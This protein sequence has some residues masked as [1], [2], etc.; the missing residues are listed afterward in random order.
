M[1]ANLVWQRRILPNGLTVLYYPRLST[2]TA[3]LSVTVNYGSNHE[4]PKAAGITHFLEH[5]LAGGSEK[6]IKLSRSIEDCGGVLDLF[7]DHEQV[8]ATLDVLPEKLPE[9]SSVLFN[10]L[11]DDAFDAEKFEV[12]RKIILNELAEFDD[13]PTVR[14]EELLLETLFKKHPVRRPVGGYPKTVK[15]LSLQQ[16]M[17]EHQ[18]NYVPE[19]MILVLAGK[20]SE[21]AQQ[22]VL[23][24]FV[25]RAYGGKS[26]KKLQPPEVG[27]P[28]SMVADEKAGITQTYLD[29]GV[30]TVNSTH[31]DA[32]ALDL[33]GTLLGGGTTSRLFAELR[34]K[35]A[36]TYDVAAVHCKGADY[37]YLSVDCAV[38]QRKLG[39]AK[40]LIFGELQKLQ[41]TTVSINELERAKQIILSGILRGIDTP[42][43]MLEII[44]YME[45][46]FKTEFALENYI[47][48]IK[49]VTPE[50][51]REVAAEHLSPDLFCTAILKPKK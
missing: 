8:S 1:S 25:D 51:I 41:D 33:I 19:N 16:L 24:E 50:N 27:K 20:I 18:T 44:N 42:H 28:K 9:E 21:K 5:M 30:R 6:R 34:E 14:V 35:H 38:S 31:K 15:G 36:V 46:Q 23:G 37:G 22:G 12:E 10:L 48:K 2:N 3:Q 7:T 11:F 32:P 47:Q 49:A 26:S 29:I 17:V 13:D 40:T 39:K 4:P 43:I 45:I